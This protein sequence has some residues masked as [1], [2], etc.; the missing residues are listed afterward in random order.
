MGY[1]QYQVRATRATRGYIVALCSLIPLGLQG[2]HTPI[3]CSLCSPVSRVRKMYPIFSIKGCDGAKWNKL[4]ISGHCELPAYVAEPI[5]PSS[6]ISTQRKMDCNPCPSPRSRP[7][8][9]IGPIRGEY[10]IHPIAYLVG[11]TRKLMTYQPDRNV[12]SMICASNLPPS[13][14]D[15]PTGVNVVRQSYLPEAFRGVNV[16]WGT[17]SRRTVGTPSVIRDGFY[18]THG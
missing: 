16:G 6:S 9:I 4:D 8:G 14:E 2:L 15:R 18:K 17:T 1:T 13:P 10:P 5:T 12:P 3:G 7:G 11:V